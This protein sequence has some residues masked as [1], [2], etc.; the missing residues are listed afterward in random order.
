MFFMLHDDPLYVDRVCADEPTLSAVLWMRTGSSTKLHLEFHAKQTQ[1]RGVA[2]V[3]H[4][5]VRVAR[6]HNLRTLKERV[7]QLRHT[8]ARFPCLET[9][10]IETPNREDFGDAQ[11]IEPLVEELQAALSANVQH[12][13]C[14]DAHKV[15]MQARKA[16]GRSVHGHAE[17][18]SPFWLLNEHGWLWKLW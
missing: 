13:T 15:A 11:A 18:V 4:C 10:V 3:H 8:L 7:L 1:L 12:R 9:L 16:T 2:H 5:L 14:D 6:E 17:L